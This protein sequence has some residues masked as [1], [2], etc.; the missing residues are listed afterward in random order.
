[1]N[2]LHRYPESSMEGKSLKPLLEQDNEKWRDYLKVG[3]EFGRGIVAQRYKFAQYF[4]GKN[5]I[6]Y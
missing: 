1:M 3:S 6:E 2:I 4:T 5:W